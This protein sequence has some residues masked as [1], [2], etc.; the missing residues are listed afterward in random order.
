MR[1]GKQWI[2][3]LTVA[4]APLGACNDAA[5]P[6][7]T[8]PADLAGTA[9][10]QDAWDTYG[11]A[12]V[13]RRTDRLEGEV[14]G[15]AFGGDGV[16]VHRS[17]GWC[18]TP[19][20]TYFD[21]QGSWE[22]LDDTHI[23]LVYPGAIPSGTLS[24]EIV[25]LTA[26]VLK[27]RAYEPAAD[28]PATVDPWQGRWVGTYTVVHDRG[29][30]GAVQETGNVVFVVDGD[31]FRVTA[32]RPLLPP[33]AAGPLAV[34]SEVTLVDELFHTADYDWT[35]N[36]GGAFAY[37]LGDGTLVLEQDDAAHKRLRTFILQ[38]AA[39]E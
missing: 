27:L 12:M 28:T 17:F 37:V 33:D 1:S 11:Q 31:K 2:L 35:L 16:L 19:P 29:E 15:Y 14:V 5:A 18:A 38:R 7:P 10:I 20:L 4:L 13:F 8:A 6:P 36:L 34:A 3:V 25:S 32:E 30:P 26:T 9:W 21:E 23:R 22:Q 24:Y 39:G